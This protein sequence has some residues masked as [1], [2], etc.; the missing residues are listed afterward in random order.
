MRAGGPSTQ[1]VH[2]VGVV[3][4]RS[5]EQVDSPFDPERAWLALAAA[6]KEFDV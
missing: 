5:T 3:I 2:L 1:Y 6:D 4:A